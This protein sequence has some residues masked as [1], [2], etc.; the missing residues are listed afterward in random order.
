MPSPSATSFAT[1]GGTSESNK[2][3]SPIIMASLPIII[4][5]THEPSAKPGFTEKSP[6]VTL[7]SE[8]GYVILYT[9]PETVPFFPKTLLRP[10]ESTCAK[11]EEQKRKIKTKAND[12]FIEDNICGKSKCYNN[13][14]A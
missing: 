4:M 13:L 14:I 12:F 11:A 5:P 10:V 6:T 1:T 8:R 7:R 9:P 3:R 2:T